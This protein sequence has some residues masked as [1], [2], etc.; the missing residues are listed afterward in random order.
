MHIIMLVYLKNQLKIIEKIESLHPEVITTDMVR[1]MMLFS[2]E[3]S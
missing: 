3:I 2:R 1:A